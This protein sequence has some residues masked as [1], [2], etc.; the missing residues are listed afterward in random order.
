MDSVPEGLTVDD[1]RVKISPLVPSIILDFY[2]M[3]DWKK[4][5]DKANSDINNTKYVRKHN[6][7]SLGVLLGKKVGH[8]V[9]VTNA[10]GA[11]YG[12]SKSKLDEAYINFMVKYLTKGTK[13]I[14][15]GMFYVN[16]KGKDFNNVEFLSAFN[17][18]NGKVDSKCKTI[19]LN[20]DG[21]LDNPSLNI[22]TFT[23]LTHD[24]TQTNT[25]LAVFDKVPCEI[26]T[27]NM[28][29][30]GLDTVLYGQDNIDTLSVYWRKATNSEGLTLD[31]IDEIKGIQK[32]FDSTE[33]LKINIAN[34]ADMLEAAYS[35][36]DDVIEGTI[37]GDQE[38]GRALNNCLSKISHINADSIESLLKDHY[39]D[40]LTL[41]KLTN[42]IKTQLSTSFPQNIE[43][44]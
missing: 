5:E 1:T 33:K 8:N 22:R 16:P 38:I 6:P 29:D 32:L 23:Q 43:A 31:K 26:I 14:I 34:I 21:S 18:I 40:L 19:L 30:I 20:M 37:E 12:S 4:E 39:Q 41:S 13:E 44:K 10:F 15:V 27:E 28:T 3:R 24:L 7:H 11:S 36:V 35:Y 9:I 42:Q 17:E 25:V 2:H